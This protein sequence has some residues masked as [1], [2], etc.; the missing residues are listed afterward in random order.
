MTD[1][2]C[3]HCSGFG[4]VGNPLDPTGKEE[5][6]FCDDCYGEGAVSYRQ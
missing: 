1:Y 3:I 2:V 6:K 5:E 4:V